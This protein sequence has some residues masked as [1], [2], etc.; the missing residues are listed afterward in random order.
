MMGGLGIH[1]V[2]ELMDELRYCRVGQYNRLT[3]TKRLGT[4][5]GGDDAAAKSVEER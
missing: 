3:M 4:A 1:L 2:R 5:A